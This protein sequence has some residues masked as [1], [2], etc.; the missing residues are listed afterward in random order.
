MHPGKEACAFHA[1]SRDE[2]VGDE[3]DKNDDSDGVVQAVEALVVG[4]IV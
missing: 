3:D 1:H 2:D 4:L